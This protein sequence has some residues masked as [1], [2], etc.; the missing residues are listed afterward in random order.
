MMR[1]KRTPA[2]GFTNWRVPAST[3]DIELK[4]TWRGCWGF[5]SM[6]SFT[7]RFLV[8]FESFSCGTFND[9][10]WFSL[11]KITACNVGFFFDHLEGVQYWFLGWCL[12][13]YVPQGDIVVPFHYFSLLPDSRRK[14][15]FSPEGTGNFLKWTF[16]S[17]F[18]G[19]FFLR[20]PRLGFTGG[21]RMTPL[22]FRQGLQ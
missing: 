22:F 11:L 19:F 2:S 8:F 6:I 7:G 20:S 16:F 15:F 3:R 13:L 5:I 1:W 10:S 14:R 17:F 21:S 9:I 18:P 4:A 12:T